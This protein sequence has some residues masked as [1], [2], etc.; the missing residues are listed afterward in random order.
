MQAELDRLRQLE[1][2]DDVSDDVSVDE[3]MKLDTRLLRD[4]RFRSG[5]WQRRARLVAC[6]FRDGDASSSDTFSPATPLAV[7]KMLIVLS[8]LHLAVASADVGDVFLQVPQTSTVLIKIPFWAMH[9]GEF[10]GG[11]CF[12]ILRKCLPGQRVCSF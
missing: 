3:C 8:L 2:I 4:W 1:V 7:I 10:G 11:K 12:W 9:A 5:R 6:E